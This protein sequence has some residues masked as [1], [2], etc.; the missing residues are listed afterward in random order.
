MDHVDKSEHAQIIDKWHDT[1]CYRTVSKISNGSDL[2]WKPQ[3]H[4]MMVGVGQ[5]LL[6]LGLQD[7]RIGSAGT[8]LSWHEAISTEYTYRRVLSC[9]KRRFPLAFLALIMIRT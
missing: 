8:A 6:E 4:L 1:S 9:V 7:Y 3:S 2:F 5:T